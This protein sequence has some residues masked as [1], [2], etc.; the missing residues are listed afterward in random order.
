MRR[1]L[2]FLLLLAGLGVT[3]PRSRGFT[4]VGALP[5][6]FT[7]NAGLIPPA[8]VYGPVNLGEEYRWTVPSI[9]YAFDESFLNYFGQRGV[10]E[11]EKAIKVLNDLP[12]MATV[13]LANYPTHSQRVNYRAR[14]L[15]MFDLKSYT[16]K[17]LMEQVGLG[18]PGR[19]VF[20]LRG[21]DPSSDPPITNYLIIQRNFDP[22][23]WAPTPYLNGSLWTYSDIYDN[24]DSPT[25]KASTITEPVDPLIL[26]EPV[27]ALVPSFSFSV[28]G[29]GSY[30]TGLTRDDVGGLRYI[31]RKENEN[32]ETLPADALTGATG[33]GGT[34]F[35]GGGGTGDGWIPVGG[36]FSGTFPG[37]QA[38]EWVPIQSPATNTVVGD[39]TGGTGGGTIPV[40]QAL[41][42]GIDKLTFVRGPA[43][44]VAGSYSLANRYQETV[45]V[46]TNGVSRS[47]RQQVVRVLTTPD[48]LFTA[49]DL[50]DTD[51]S[52]AAIDRTA[53]AT[54]NDAINGQSPLDGPGQF[55]GTLT[56]SFNKVGPVLFNIAPSF[57]GQGN[58]L[59]DFV[60]GSFDGTTNDPAVYPSG[61]S[62]KDLERIAFGS[63]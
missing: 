53:I 55:T 25:V 11:V 13:N 50:A 8:D 15:A 4:L 56:I 31:Y 21:R 58:S 42:G 28:F 62:I 57:I 34:V 29:I 43:V 32:V 12:T 5:A 47:L 40:S 36:D 35:T 37:G 14:D 20:T 60:W 26:S 16:L 59:G 41:R 44:Y 23:T 33:T 63:R 52:V 22:E 1:A 9:F 39:P 54:S 49:E 27:A 24:Q 17:I 19:F 48:I 46:I 7:D 3:T 6:W 51:T 10:E 45:L 61:T 18:T 30:I 2:L 38:S